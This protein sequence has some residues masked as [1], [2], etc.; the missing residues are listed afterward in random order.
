M[1]L[2]RFYSPLSTGVCQGAVTSGAP[3]FPVTGTSFPPRR[4]AIALSVL[5][6]AFSVILQLCLYGC[7]ASTEHPFS[8]ASP[9]FPPL[10]GPSFSWPPWPSSQVCPP[11]VRGKGFGWSAVVA[12]LV[13]IVLGVSSGG[14][15]QTG[16]RLK[17]LVHQPFS[18]LMRV[19]QYLL[20]SI[21]HHPFLTG[22]LQLH[23]QV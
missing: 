8:Q 6:Q 4:P 19:V 7:S 1:R 23:V 21:V 3:F 20:M 12:L 18:G 10:K 13:A 16:R 17:L 22:F 14:S 11:E 5:F 15:A 2:Q 9:Q